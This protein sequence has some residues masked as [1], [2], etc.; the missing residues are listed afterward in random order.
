MIRPI[1]YIAL[2][3]L[4]TVLPTVVPTVAL[5][6]NL[7]WDGSRPS[8]NWNATQGVFPFDTNW[9]S[10]VQIPEADDTVT[11]PDTAADFVVTLNGNRTVLSATFSGGSGY[12]L[13][14][15]T[16]TLATGDL[17]ANDA[18]THTIN[19]NVTL[20]GVGDW[21]LDANVELNGDLTG[22]FDLNL[23]GT[24]LLTHTGAASSVGAVNI[25]ANNTLRLDGGSLSATGGLDNTAG[26]NLNFR[27]GA[28]NVSGGPFLPQASVG[29]YTIEGATASDLAHLTLGEGATFNVNFT[30][31]VAGLEDGAMTL[32]DG[33]VVNSSNGEI[34]TNST[35]TGTVTVS[36]TDPNGIPSAWNITGGLDIEGASSSLL[37]DGGGQVTASSL[38]VA[39]SSQQDA[40][41]TVSGSDTGGNPSALVL[42]GT[43]ELGFGS[44]TNA[45]LDVLAGAR[46]SNNNAFLGDNPDS[47]SSAT[48]T[49]TGADPNS[50]PATWTSSGNLTVGADFHTSKVTTVNIGSDGLVTVAGTTSVLSSGRIDL[51]GGRFEFGRTTLA[52][53]T[54]FNAISGELAGAVEISGSHNINDLPSL[55]AVGGVDTTGV[56]FLNSGQI[57]G[58]GTLVEDFGNLA[59]GEVVANPLELMRFLGA[60]TNNEG[61][62][63]LVG[64]AMDFSQGL[65]NA[66]GGLVQG[67][68][69]LRADAGTTN[70]GTMAFNGTANVIGDVTNNASG[71]I[72]TT[73]GTTTFF[74][75]VVN[76][77][78]IQTNANSFSVYFGSYS[79]NGDT[80]T[81]TVIMEGDLKPGSSPG[82][83]NFAGDVS[84]GAGAGLDVEI[85]SAAGVPG[86]DFDQVKRGGRGDAGRDF[87]GRLV[88][89]PQRPK[90]RLLPDAGRDI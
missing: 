40:A 76:N 75:D 80:G 22:G 19:S 39:P 72:S 84:F 79:G 31:T 9:N 53:Y 17:T 7:T 64:G 56:W 33:A 16:L 20:G 83:M 41:V 1:T 45:T 4:L 77:G 74:D 90:Q 88:G 18:A 35:D 14:D 32:T 50:N 67:N 71:V 82:V 47:G 21:A 11:F 15:D 6:V 86:T 27:D 65:M 28:L 42:S 57:S 26:G 48:V 8:T 52:E 62:L 10:F 70:D 60:A 36:G 49:V 78:T 68:G 13:N 24:G 3:L 59:G 55:V 66:S 30:L 58:E 81:G 44:P 29:N 5:A 69:T 43:L 46:V 38:D 87:A 61:Q 51:M 12:T 2:F 85:V 73:A 89:G 25:G 63:T 23:T 34:A 37:I 54:A